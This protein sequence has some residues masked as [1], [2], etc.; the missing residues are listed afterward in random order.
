M[1][2]G[3]SRISDLR[4]ER[5]SIVPVGQAYA[6]YEEESKPL[7]IPSLKIDQTGGGLVVSGAG[8]EMWNP[9]VST[10]DPQHKDRF[11]KRAFLTPSPHLSH[12]YLSH[13]PGT[14]SSI[15]S[16]SLVRLNK[17]AETLHR[18]G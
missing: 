17:Y 15:Q 2:T 18:H 13:P 10:T 16:K 5:L 8:L 12:L 7:R 1:P 4:R 6:R 9:A 3:A 14:I 11:W